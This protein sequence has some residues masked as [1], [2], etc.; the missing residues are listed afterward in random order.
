MKKEKFLRTKYIRELER[1]VNRIVDF[2]KNEHTK[3]EIEKHIDKIFAPLENIQ[4]VHLKNEYL[5]ELEKFVQ[6]YANTHL[7]ENSA[8]E[9]RTNALKEANLLRKLKRTK[10]YQKQ[11]HKKYDL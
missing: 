4:K 6:K 2:F 3:E 8:D 5:K 1:F 7:S 10:S 9:I 11:K